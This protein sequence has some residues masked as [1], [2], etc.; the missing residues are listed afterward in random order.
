M[1]PATR[2][3]G[4]PAPT[5]LRAVF[6][7]WW[8]LAA[9]WLMMGLELPAVSAVMARLPDPTV[10]LAAYGGVVFPL[11][12]LIESP[13]VMLL[14]ASTALSRDWASYRLVRRAMFVMS[15]TL[16]AVHALVAFTPLYDVVAARLLGVPADILEPARLGLRIMLPWT[17]SI[18]YRRSQQGVLIRH[19]RTWAVGVGTAVRLTAN[20]VV[21]SL[22]YWLGRAP[23]IVVGTLAVSAGVVSEAIF[24]GFAVHPVLRDRVRPAPPAAPPLTMARFVR[25]YTPLA[26][27]P[28]MAFFTTP[29]AA[30]AMSRMPRALESL[31]V[32]PVVNGLVFTQRSVGFAMNEVVVAMLERPRAAHALRRFSLTLA[33]VTSALLLVI[34]AS[35]LGPL[36]FGGV[37]AL[38]PALMALGVVGLWCAFPL[39]ALT[40]LQSWYQG[41]LVHG[42]RTRAVSESVAVYLVVMAGL[43]YAGVALGRVSGLTVTLLANSVA[44]AVLVAWLRLR[45]R[46]PLAEL[47]AR[48][49]A[50]GAGAAP[51]AVGAAGAAAGP[52]A[53]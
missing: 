28:L 2:T 37:S 46:A 25:F 47:R 12:L 34:A 53:R 20:V 19:G 44:T 32:W 40:A 9:S 51:A 33:A 11:A 29:L 5:G 36:W 3:D 6:H 24:S 7:V 14:S 27:T 38:P 48:D 22:G 17:L 10:S 49:A 23:G 43:L 50:A 8:P 30:A 16:T 26:A 45:S 52:A 41:I 4:G 13:I 31:A 21:L 1:T 42:H 39:P 18:A 35:P 15:G